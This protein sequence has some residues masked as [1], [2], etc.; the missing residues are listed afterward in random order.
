MNPREKILDG[1]L[2]TLGLQATLKMLALGGKTGQLSV[3]TFPDHAEVGRAREVLNVYLKRGNIVALD[4]IPPAPIDLAEMFRL[5]RRLH[6]R[7]AQEIKER[8]GNQLPQVLA[9]LVERGVI[10]PAEQQQRIEFAIIQEISRAMRW[11]QGTFEFLNN[12]RVADTTLTPLNVDQILLE[13]I[14]MVDEWKAAGA[15]LRRENLPRWVPEFN[16]NISALALSREDVQILYLCNGQHP[17][18][19]ITYALLMPES[20]VAARVETMVGMHLIEIVDDH[21]E[22]KLEQSLANALTVSHGVLKQDPRMTPEQRLM[23][24]VD[25]MGTCVNKLLSHHVTFARAV[26]GRSMPRTEALRYLEA[27]FGPVLRRVQDDFPISETIL[28]QDGQIEYSEILQ[29]HKFVKGDDLE[30]LAWEVA[31]AFQRLMND[32]FQFVVLDELGPNRSSRRY[33]EMWETFAQEIAGE[34]ERHYVRRIA[35]PRRSGQ[36]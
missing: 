1:D 27:S 15:H 9:M 14:R 34:M 8:T 32:T 25:V 4:S 13:A 10:T 33:M 29:L 3:V 23:M 6:R 22:R 35:T 17:I 24:L 5:L 21:L 7:D 20:R 12:V 26:R 19:A 18:S 2:Q 36:P 30:S 11:E 31:Q 28:F 16:G